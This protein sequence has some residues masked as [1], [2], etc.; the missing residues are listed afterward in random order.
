M[1]TDQER[2]TLIKT[3]LSS[4]FSY[5]KSRTPEFGESDWWILNFSCLLTITLLSTWQVTGKVAMSLNLDSN[6]SI[7]EVCRCKIVISDLEVLTNMMVSEISETYPLMLNSF[8]W[9]VTLLPVFTLESGS[10]ARTHRI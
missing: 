4:I 8:H 3:Q 9:N 1:A 5:A 2:D 10:A 7:P 6:D